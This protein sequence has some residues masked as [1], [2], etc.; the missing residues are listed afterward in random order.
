MS[1]KEMPSQ[2]PQEQSL[3]TPLVRICSSYAAG[4]DWEVFYEEEPGLFRCFVK[5]PFCPE[6]EYGIVPVSDWADIPFLWVSQH[7]KAFS[8]LNLVRQSMELL[9]KVNKA[10]R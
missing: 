4:W 1:I 8:N 7:D 10:M 2:M 5:S 6:G 9:Q 3:I